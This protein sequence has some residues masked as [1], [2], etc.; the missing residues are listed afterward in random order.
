MTR[1]KK[2]LRLCVWILFCCLWIAF[3]FSNSLQPATASTAVSNGVLLRINTI[4]QSMGSPIQLSSFMIRKAA[5]F[6]EFAVLGFLLRLG[7]PPKDK[8]EKAS[9]FSLLIGT[10]VAF[11]DEGIQIFT[12]GRSAQI[13]DVGID[14]FGVAVAVIIAHTLLS[15]AIQYKNR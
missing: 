3:I 15:K 5:H 1:R 11:T 9:A 7:M 12:E 10:I 13:R 2:Q 6:T 8:K 4:L 14:F